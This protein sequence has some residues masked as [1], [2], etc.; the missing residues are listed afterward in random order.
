M[1][2]VRIVNIKETSEI[3]GK[4]EM[5]IKITVDDIVKKFSHMEETFLELFR[6]KEKIFD[7]IHLGY[8]NL[9]SN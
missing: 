1:K 3:I 9:L 5:K 2:H 8:S 6:H 7:R 4:L